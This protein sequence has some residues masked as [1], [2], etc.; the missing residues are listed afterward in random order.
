[1]PSEGDVK[2]NVLTKQQ[3]A[4]LHALQKEALAEAEKQNPTYIAGLAG[5]A[6]SSKPEGIFTVLESLFDEVM[7]AGKKMPEQFDPH[8]V[9]DIP[10]AVD[11]AASF[12]LATDALRPR[13][14]WSFSAKKRALSHEVQDEMDKRAWVAVLYLK[15]ARSFLNFWSGRAKR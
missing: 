14:R 3:W 5:A 10:A 8:I 12:Y 7:K 2:S 11:A 4:E 6:L 15:Q 1:V 9:S 13:A